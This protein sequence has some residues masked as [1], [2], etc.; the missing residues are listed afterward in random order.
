MK[1]TRN[2]HEKKF[3]CSYMYFTDS[4]PTW[5][6]QCALHLKFIT[7]SAHVHTQET[8]LPGFR[9]VTITGGG[10]SITVSLGRGGCI[11]KELLPV[12]CHPKISRPYSSVVDCVNHTRCS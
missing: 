7:S 3:Q 10:T 2:I 4:S 12:T 8:Y 5:Q 11:N 6:R 9:S 1:E